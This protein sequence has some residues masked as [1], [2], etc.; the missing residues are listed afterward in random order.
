MNDARTEKDFGFTGD[1]LDVWR[2]VNTVYNAFVDHDEERLVSVI[3][4]EATLWDS[5]HREARRGHIMKSTPR[6]PSAWG[7]PTVLEVTS[8]AVKVWGETAMVLH[9]LTAS[10]EDASLNEELR[11]T[12]VL[13]SVEGRWLIVH[14][15]EEKLLF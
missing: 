9:D 13:R 4:D 8:P 6:D 5:A 1:Q 10:F 15:H 11:I 7:P 3:A 14:H 12:V 2:A